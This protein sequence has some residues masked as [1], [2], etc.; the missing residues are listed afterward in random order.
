MWEETQVME[1]KVKDDDGDVRK[2]RW[3]WHKGKVLGK[4]AE[5]EM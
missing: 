2:R 5:M 1:D 3:R 4:G